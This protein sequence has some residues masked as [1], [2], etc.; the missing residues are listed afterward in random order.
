[1][2]EAEDI[3]EMALIPLSE[4]AE[5]CSRR[6]EM[7]KA[8]QGVFL[9]ARRAASGVV[10]IGTLGL[11]SRP[12]VSDST[13]PKVFNSSLPFCLTLFITEKQTESLHI[14]RL[15]LLRTPEVH[16]LSG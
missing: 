10:D 9:G 11:I 5:G 4:T 14:C 6:I 2:L 7:L 16:R 8:K 15:C 1:M 12:C 13:I 3:M